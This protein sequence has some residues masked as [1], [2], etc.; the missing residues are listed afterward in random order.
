MSGF[1]DQALSQQ[2]TL[3]G[4]NNTAGGDLGQAVAVGTQTKLSGLSQL[5]QSIQEFERNAMNAT[6]GY[7]RKD[8]KDQLAEAKKF[9][10]GKDPTEVQKALKAG[11]L[12]FAH[13][14]TA[15][16]YVNRQYGEAV[17]GQTLNK[18]HAD[19]Q[20]GAS[21]FNSDEEYK[22]ALH[23]AI[24]T[25]LNDAGVNTEDKQQMAGVY[26]STGP[27]MQ[28][29]YNAHVQILS[30][31]TEAAA[32]QRETG[33][34][35]NSI[36]P[37]LAR[38]Y[39][40]AAI[41]NLQEQLHTASQNGLFL[42][43][44]KKKV[45]IQS[46]GQNLQA[47]GAVDALEALRAMPDPANSNKPLGEMWGGLIDGYMPGAKQRN[48]VIEP[49]SYAIA[50]SHLASLAHDG[51]REGILQAYTGLQQSDPKV[52]ESLSHSLGGLLTAADNAIQRKT[53]ESS[54]Q[55]RAENLE[56][57]KNIKVNDLV[58]RIN[59]G[60]NTWTADNLGIN[61][62]TGKEWKLEGENGLKA[63]IKTALLE[64]A[65]GM[66]QAVQ[67]GSL[68]MDDAVKAISRNATNSQ[69]IMDEFFTNTTRAG[70]TSMQQAGQDAATQGN[71]YRLG[72]E[73]KNLFAFYKEG[74]SNPAIM[75]KLGNEQDKA[76]ISV[77]ADLQAQGLSDEQIGLRLGIVKE[78]LDNPI[79]L[80]KIKTL[81]EEKRLKIGGHFY[82]SRGGWSAVVMPNQ[83]MY[84]NNQE[85]MRAVQ[86]KTILLS[87][88]D[89]DIDSAFTKASEEEIE[90]YV[91]VGS[92]AVSKNVFSPA[93]KA[94]NK[95]PAM[96]LDDIPDYA[97]KEVNKERNK[98]AKLYGSNIDAIEVSMS[99]DNKNFI[100][101]TP[102]SYNNSNTVNIIPANELNERMQQQFF[103]DH[104]KIIEKGNYHRKVGAKSYAPDGLEKLL[105]TFKRE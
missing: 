66:I 94:T 9:L 30:N 22:A 34:I 70:V 79:K 39:P 103:T 35:V 53:V 100:L 37:M 38:S 97:E 5:Q 82:T 62:V 52:A 4:V 59:A 32:T 27:A 19:M 12:P 36:D 75:A 77:G 31:R 45:L 23:D 3:Q 26:D 86:Q 81:L 95:Y 14:Q 2:K 33:K 16:E 50:Q 101:K 105:P 67:D 93:M 99:S 102:M 24:T 25:G 83:V 74:K 13:N 73:I 47:A 61:N 18:F 49:H 96:S 17:A 7:K 10:A 68:D 87:A 20:S 8:D 46:I 58:N 55:I 28:Q 80:G 40:K 91:G 78:T 51:N 98:L 11:G 57:A 89:G 76:W 85:F 71:K 63:P 42:T 104:Q 44:D 48:S 90:N 29:M 15:M 88:V 92:L 72:P 21:V 64:Q 43:N 60:N 41:S 84:G 1:L 65:Q 69:G 54:L 6:Q 56:A